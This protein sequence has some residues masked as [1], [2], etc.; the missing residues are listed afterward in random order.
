[1][2]FQ[3]KLDSSECHYT[4]SN[5]D[6][7]KFNTSK[8][9]HCLV[10]L[11][12]SLSC[13][14]L[15]PICPAVAEEHSQAQ[16]TFDQRFTR[17]SEVTLSELRALH[18]QNPVDVYARYYLASALLEN[19]NDLNAVAEALVLLNGLEKMPSPPAPSWLAEWCM[20]RQLEA[21]SR[22]QILTA[23]SW[24]TLP[25]RPSAEDPTIQAFLKH[26]FDSIDSTLK[27]IRIESASQPDF[28]ADAVRSDLRELVDKLRARWAYVNEKQAQTGHSLDDLMEATLAEVQSK[29]TSTEVDH[30][31]RRFVGKLCDGHAAIHMTTGEP[32]VQLPFQAID[33]AD[34]V[35]VMTTT[36]EEQAL[37]PGDRLLEVDGRTVEN[38]IAERGAMYPV[39]T[40][41]ARRV[42]GVEQISIIHHAAKAV[43]L[44]IERDAKEQVI[45]CKLTNHE[46]AWEL[47]QEHENW[48]SAKLLTP[49]IGY[50]RVRSWAPDKLMPKQTASELRAFDQVRYEQID[51]ALKLLKTTSDI[52]IDVRGNSG[53]RDQLCCYLAGY[54]LSNRPVKP[55]VLRFRAMPKA[56]GSLPNEAGDD[57]FYNANRAPA[58]YP[59]VDGAVWKTRLC[60]LV[61][62]KSFS[63]T[64]TFL[65]L[66][67]SQ[68]PPDRIHT[69]GRP[70][71]GGIGGPALLGE[72]HNTK[73]ALNASTCRAYSLDGQLLEGHPARID[74]P[75]IWTRADVTSGTDPDLE[76]ALKVIALQK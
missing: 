12:A 59:T 54:F 9:W 23:K 44:R 26:K 37:K 36:K 7:A 70:S 51:S 29:M 57:G 63:A 46:L 71:Q 6:R 61:D 32:Y 43:P 50:L 31:L 67:T 10:V 20:A 38:I 45:E 13:V 22:I 49:E 3:G 40:E 4:M 18:K 30:L 74:V 16:L 53:G 28:T 68:L 35:I 1:M 56:D 2:Q 65:D 72:L 15:E 5:F 21:A 48:I 11:I 25:K 19:S 39:S 33:T 17:G 64:D 8:L 27:Q 47:A 73:S 66:L 55:Y 76:A 52:I 60:L 69:I 34:G 14:G 62:G 24:A 58:E 42:H 41:G 75:V